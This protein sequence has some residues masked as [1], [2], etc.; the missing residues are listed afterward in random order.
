MGNF[1]KLSR[2]VVDKPPIKPVKL[3]GTDVD[4]VLTDA[5]MYY[6]NKGNELKKFNTHDGMSFKLLS[7]KGI[8]SAIIT[9][10][11]TNIVKNRSKKLNVNYLYQSVSGKKKLD[12]IKEICMK[13]NSSKSIRNQFELN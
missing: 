7:E 13:E 9:S 12:V 3:F 2:Y 5:G 10:E 8:K 11:E 1:F 4:G 6:D